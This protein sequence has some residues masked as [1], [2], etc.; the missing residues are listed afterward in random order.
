[1][2]LSQRPLGFMSFYK[3]TLIILLNPLSIQTLIYIYV[4][5]STNLFSNTR[6]N[7]PTAFSLSLSLSLTLSLSLSLSLT[8]TQT[9]TNTHT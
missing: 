2:E 9:H 5:R 3:K 1:M 4:L 7:T 6:I 8:H